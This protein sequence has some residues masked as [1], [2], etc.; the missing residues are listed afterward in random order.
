MEPPAPQAG[1]PG[2]VA[3]LL[4]AETALSRTV[5]A[6]AQDLEARAA[7]V[8]EGLHAAALRGRLG[9]LPRAG[10][11]VDLCAL[12]DAFQTGRAARFPPPLA[13]SLHAPYAA[14]PPG[15]APARPPRPRAADPPGGQVVERPR[16]GASAMC[17][18][19]L[20]EQRKQ[21]LLARV[22]EL[23]RRGP[24]PLAFVQTGY[25]SLHIE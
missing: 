14:G 23:A 16:Y 13:V 18:A 3:L 1:D 21:A 8:V 4:R 10:P 20:Q 22:A 2:D 5:R 17:G 15:R 25:R 6:S 24:Y 19:E 11:F 7:R 12:A 9:R